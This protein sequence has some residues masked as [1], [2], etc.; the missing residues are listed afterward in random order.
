MKR[1]IKQITLAFVILAFA[2]G[3]AGMSHTQQTT[4]S[5]GAIGAAGGAVLGA[6]V[7]GNPAIGAAVGGA[8]GAG[9]GY[10]IGEHDQ[11]RW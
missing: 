2:V 5:G 9:V 8:A 1:I 4:L 6:V 7:G 3:C 11:G 10:I